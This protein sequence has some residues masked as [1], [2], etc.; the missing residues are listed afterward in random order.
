MTI[1]E[2]LYRCRKAK[3]Y[4]QE[5]M[6]ETLGVSRQTVS[7]W[8]TGETLPEIGKLRPLAGAFG[9][10]TDWLL[11][12]DEGYPYVPPQAAPGG[13]ALPAPPEK[14][15]FFSRPYTWIPGVAG[16]LYGF[17]LGVGAIPFFIAVRGAYRDVPDPPDMLRGFLLLPVVF[18]VVAAVLISGGIW[19]LIKYKIAHKA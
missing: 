18:W 4:S 16:I 8:E 12:E 17:F 13:T 3:G 11:D 7:K 15:S 10:T 1:A 9:V 19:I 14:K 2:K 6:A 5:T